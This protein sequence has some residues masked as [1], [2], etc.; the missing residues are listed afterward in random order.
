MKWTSKTPDVGAYWYRESPDSE[1]EVRLFFGNGRCWNA[2]ENKFYQWYEL[3]DD[4]EFSDEAVPIP[5]G[6]AKDRLKFNWGRT[7]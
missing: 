4:C 7:E 1:P 6:V 2:I 3:P 5:L